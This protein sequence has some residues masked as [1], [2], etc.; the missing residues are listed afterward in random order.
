V[1]PLRFDIHLRRMMVLPRLLLL[2][3]RLGGQVRRLHAANGRVDLEIDAPP[4]VA[5][6]FRPYLERVVEVTEIRDVAGD[7]PDFVER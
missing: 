2:V 4:E 7:T 1:T 6:R 5:H 3:I